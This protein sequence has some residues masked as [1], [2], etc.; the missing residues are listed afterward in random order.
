MINSEFIFN[1]EHLLSRI[2]VVDDDEQVRELVQSLLTECGY[3]ITIA[4]D[5][6]AAIR[7][8]R[9]VPF[10][11]VITDLVMPDMEGIELIRE[12]RG[13]D[14]LVKIIAMSGGLRGATETYLKTAKLMGA[15]HVLAKP[16]AVDDLFTI[17]SA[18]LEQD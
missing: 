13:L 17:V 16:F 7:Q 1:Q 3:D 14:P 12:L 15:Q 5:G 9:E 4:T 2:L 8:Y 10:D 11:L 18:A 6:Q